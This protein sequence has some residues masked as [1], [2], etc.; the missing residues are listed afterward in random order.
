[1]TYQYSDAA[2]NA[3]LTAIAD[4]INAPS[5]GAQTFDIMDAGNALLVSA[6]NLSVTHDAGLKRLTIPLDPAIVQ[7]IGTGTAATARIADGLGQTVVTMPCQQGTSAVPGV[8]VLDSLDIVAGA[9]VH[10][11]PIVIQG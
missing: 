5:I 11:Q 8:C 7:A 10:I 2:V 3:C 9:D 4:L 1:M 6:T